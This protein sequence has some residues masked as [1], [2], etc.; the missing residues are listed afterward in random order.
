MKEKSYFSPAC[1]VVRMGQRACLCVSETTA[2]ST[3]NF[4]VDLV[5][6]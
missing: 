3:E 6:F 4:E 1:S 5:E 2:S